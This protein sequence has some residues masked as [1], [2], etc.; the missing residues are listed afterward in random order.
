MASKRRN[1]FH[2]NKTQETTEN[3]R[4]FPK[5][6]LFVSVQVDSLCLKFFP[7]RGS[8]T[9]G[10]TQQAAGGMCVTSLWCCDTPARYRHILP[11]GESNGKRPDPTVRQPLRDGGGRKLYWAPRVDWFEGACGAILFLRVIVAVDGTGISKRV[12]FR[13]GEEY[14]RELWG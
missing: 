14:E 12:P 1:M 6:T 13:V 8:V 3:G 5:Y 7:C 4:V 11:E 2:K 10:E 9:Q